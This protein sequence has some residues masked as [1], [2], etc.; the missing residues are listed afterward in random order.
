M[1]SLNVSSDRRQSAIFTGF[2]GAQRRGHRL[3]PGQRC[4][5]GVAKGITSF[6]T[7]RDNSVSNHFRQQ[8][9]RWSST[10]QVIIREIDGVDCIECRLEDVEVRFKIGITLLKTSCR[11]QAAKNFG[12]KGRRVLEQANNAAT[13]GQQVGSDNVITCF[14]RTGNPKSNLVLIGRSD[15]R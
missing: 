6:R 1:S 11:C 3:S 4:G 14:W 2:G 8:N 9:T 13:R 12:C 7:V 10:I 5:E 15:E